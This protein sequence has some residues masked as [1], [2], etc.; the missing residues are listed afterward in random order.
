MNKRINKKSNY[1]FP[2]LM[3]ISMIAGCAAGW[4][5]P[6]V[7]DEEGRIVEAGATV[8]K[9]LGTMFLN[10]MFC[11]LVPMVF[12]SISSAM[13]N[14]RSRKRAGK[15]MLVTVVTFVVTGLIAALLMY[16]AMCFLMPYLGVTQT[17]SPQEL[18]KDGSLLEILI[19]FVSVKDFSEL[20][21]SKNMLPLIV[22]SILFGLGVNLSVGS[23]SPIAVFLEHLASAMMKMIQMIMY[24]APV[25]FFGIFADMVAVNGAQIVGAYSKTLFAYYVICFLYL[26]TAF[27]AYAWFGGGKGAVAEMFRHILKPAV[28]SWSSCSSIATIPV[29]LEETDATGI[30]RDISEL[31]LPLGATVHMDGCCLSCVLKI[32]FVFAAFGMDFGNPMVLVKL[33]LVA[34]VSSVGM[35]GTVGGGYI[36]EYIMCTLFFPN[37][38]DAAFPILLALGSMVDPPAT[39]VN[40]CGDY[41]V[42]YIV[43]RFVDG[44][45]WLQKIFAKN[46]H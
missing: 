42:C 41:V 30:S 23:G 26:M 29:N 16:G 21:S 13:A 36:G 44:R 8:L 24:Y 6:V 45:D 31:V 11:V 27:P 12:A 40:A 25:A 14:I 39:M 15:I 46:N 5:F 43:S 37:Q 28:V 33:L 34:V 17:V 1:I 18:T 35:S 22:F 3:L 9:P 38:M 4:M 32:T 10:L 2:G 7:Q 20:L 19:G